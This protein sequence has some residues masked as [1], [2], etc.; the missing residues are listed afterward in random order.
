VGQFAE[1][2]FI[3]VNPSHTILNSGTEQKKKHKKLNGNYSLTG[4]LMSKYFDSL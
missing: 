4:S 3:D 2:F 1:L